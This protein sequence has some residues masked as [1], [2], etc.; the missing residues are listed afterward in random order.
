MSDSQ[1]A[2]INS[3]RSLPSGELAHM[4]FDQLV[5]LADPSV[6]ANKHLFNQIG[7]HCSGLEDAYGSL[8]IIIDQLRA[9]RIY[10]LTDPSLQVAKSYIWESHRKASSA[11]IDKYVSNLC[12]LLR[13]PSDKVPDHPCITG[14]LPNW[15][16][17]GDEVDC[18]LTVARELHNQRDLDL[19]WWYGVVIREISPKAVEVFWVGTPPKDGSRRQVV[20][21]KCNPSIVKRK[22]IRSHRDDAYH[23]GNEQFSVAYIRQNCLPK[24]H[25]ADPFVSDDYGRKAAVVEPGGANG[26]SSGGSAAPKG[27]IATPKPK[28]PVKGPNKLGK[29]KGEGKGKKQ[30]GSGSA[31]RPGRGSSPEEQTKQIIMEP[32]VFDW[33]APF[34]QSDRIESDLALLQ[35][36]PEL[37][38]DKS[39]FS[40][41]LQL[42]ERLRSGQGVMYSAAAKFKQYYERQADA[43]SKYQVIHVVTFDQ[44][45]KASFIESMDRSLKAKYV[46]AF[47]RNELVVLCCLLAHPGLT[48]TNI[49]QKTR[50]AQ[51]SG[52]VR[53]MSFVPEAVEKFFHSRL[54]KLE[55]IDDVNHPKHME[56][57][58]TVVINSTYCH[59]QIVSYDYGS[60]FQT[61]DTEEC[62]LIFKGFPEFLSINGAYV[63]VKDEAAGG[64]ERKLYA[65]VMSKKAAKSLNIPEGLVIPHKDFARVLD[66]RWQEGQETAVVKVQCF[67]SKGLGEPDDPICIATFELKCS[68][69]ENTETDSDLDLLVI[70]H[71]MFSHIGPDGHAVYQDM[72]VA[73]CSPHGTVLANTT[74]RSNRD[75]EYGANLVPRHVNLNVGSTFKPVGLGEQAAHCDGNFYQAKGQWAEVSSEGRTGP[76]HGLY[77]VSTHVPLRS[78]SDMENAGLIEP[79]F[80]RGRPHQNSMSFL[81]NV[82]GKTTL[83]FPSE[84]ATRHNPNH[85]DDVPFGG[86]SAFS[87]I[88]E[89]LGSLYGLDPNERPHLYAHSGDLRQFPSAGFSNLLLILAA[90]Q[91]VENIRSLN[92]S[93]QPDVFRR[94][95]MEV[96]TALKH[97]I[98]D[99]LTTT[100]YKASSQAQIL[101]Q[102]QARAIQDPPPSQASS[103]VASAAESPVATPPKP[104]DCAQLSQTSSGGGR[105]RTRS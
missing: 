29:G 68:N 97:F 77:R 3:Q 27:P 4:E 5:L 46:E 2:E 11:A 55:L 1:V 63:T 62:P 7:L 86:L 30:P 9:Q 65:Q 24:Q 23:G 52:M 91:R 81:M 90:K 56:P 105:K 69:P 80:L 95:L 99:M 49:D 12:H 25:V 100:T 16:S 59:N 35:C 85:V 72:D 6:K 19:E 20:S 64:E 40:H 61:L 57:L 44:G 31:G 58:S 50:V 53:G 37:H 10:L 76:N 83:T 33:L 94:R 45:K 93:D 102:V 79:V 73:G 88:Q 43:L 98:F 13:C 75:L 87:F 51:K 21:A 71:R 70:N 15:Q 89:H 17:V 39:F 28:P 48:Y 14:T 78:D 42:L 34:L 18:L 32:S 41:Y 60:E 74:V 84:G 36:R 104:A 8:R 47:T 103:L 82:N 22:H 26:S 92:Q 101:E 38:G 66:V 67:L 54:R 96:E